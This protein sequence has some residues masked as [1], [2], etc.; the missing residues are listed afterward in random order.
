MLKSCKQ[1]NESFE[2]RSAYPDQEFCSPQ[3]RK[4][5]WQ[6]LHRTKPK[7][8]KILK[9]LSDKF[10]KFGLDLLEQIDLSQI[11][12]L[13]LINKIKDEGGIYGYRTKD[14]YIYIGSSNKLQT[15]L[16]SYVSDH[17][18]RDS[19]LF[20]IWRIKYTN[21]HFF[22]FYTNQYKELEAYLILKYKPIFNSSLQKKLFTVKGIMEEI[23]NIDDELFK[24][25][26][27]FINTDIEGDYLWIKKRLERKANR[28]IKKT[29]KQNDSLTEL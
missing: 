27:K 23:R 21:V 14:S 25:R 22:Y 6:V 12:N 24:I 29:N 16:N 20:N 18:S 10:S 28:E 8:D 3:C 15:R 19:L 1:C 9:I 17:I 4:H 13:T 5:Y 2:V 11:S 26:K 7:H